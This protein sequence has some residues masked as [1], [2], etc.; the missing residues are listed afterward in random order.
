[1]IN[2][3]YKFYKMTVFDDEVNDDDFDGQQIAVERFFSLM[4]PGNVKMII[5]RENRADSEIA[6]LEKMVVH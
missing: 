4:K 5:E 2:L 3:R 1:M 6:E